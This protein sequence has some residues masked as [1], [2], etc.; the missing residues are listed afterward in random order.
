[1]PVTHAALALTAAMLAARLYLLISR[2]HA[3]EL[4]TTADARARARARDWAR[5]RADAWAWAW[6]WADAWPITS[7]LAPGSTGRCAAAAA[8]PA[9]ARLGAR[10]PA[11]R[12][13]AAQPRLSNRKTAGVRVTQDIR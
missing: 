6:A 13:A 11:I 10:I 9:M 3:G 12:A 8:G 1:M 4:V 7:A 2:S 5:A